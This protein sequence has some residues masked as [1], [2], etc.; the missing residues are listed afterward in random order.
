MQMLCCRAPC[1]VVLE[2]RKRVMRDEC[3]ITS[4]VMPSREAAACAKH[5]RQCGWQA[6]VSSKLEVRVAVSH[7]VRLC[8]R[9]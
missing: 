1:G 9:N 8:Q 7:T 2:G 6:G 4:F 5:A 3:I